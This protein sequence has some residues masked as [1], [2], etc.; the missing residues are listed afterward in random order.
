MLWGFPVD[1]VVERQTGELEALTE[2]AKALV[3]PLELPELLE[4]APRG[5]QRGSCE[6]ASALK[7]CLERASSTTYQRL[8]PALMSKTG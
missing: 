3:A 5:R 7:R 6:L 8:A 1:R 2:V 4:A